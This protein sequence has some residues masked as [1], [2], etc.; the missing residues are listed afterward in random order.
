MYELYEDV[1]AQVLLEQRLKELRKQD[2]KSEG[3]KQ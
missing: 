1:K 2:P 3:T